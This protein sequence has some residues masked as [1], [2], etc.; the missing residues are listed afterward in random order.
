MFE[1]LFLALFLVAALSALLAWWWGRRL[2]A[3][4]GVPIHSQVVY[5][6]TGAWERIERPLFSQR[7]AL[8]GRPDYIVQENGTSVPIEVKPNRVAD[9]PRLSDTMQLAAYGLL[10]EEAYHTRPPYGLL[11]Y[12]NTVFRVEL[13]EE[14]RMQLFQVLGEMREDLDAAEV[15]R[16]HDDARRCRACGYR[17]ECGQVIE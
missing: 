4:T 12:R 14:L 5:S 10:I 6:D 11:K 7:Y 2:H 17:E 1:F 16:S 9:E 8:T 13:T 15:A 3:Q